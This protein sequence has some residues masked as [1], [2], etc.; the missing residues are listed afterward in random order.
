MYLVVT[1]CMDKTVHQCMN[2]MNH[3]NDCCNPLHSMERFLFGFDIVYKTN[4][5]ILSNG[6]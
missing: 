3:I 2:L 4:M 5:C 6:K 1:A